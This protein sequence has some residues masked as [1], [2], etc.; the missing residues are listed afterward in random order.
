MMKESKYLSN[1]Y[2]AELKLF[3]LKEIILDNYAV[4]S[5]HAYNFTLIFH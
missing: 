5:I 3:P 4:H 2:F 1:V